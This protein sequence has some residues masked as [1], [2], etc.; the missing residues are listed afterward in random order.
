[1]KCKIVKLS[2]F[3]GNKAS[4][5]T[6]YLSDDNLTLFDIFLNENANSFKS[7]TLDILKRL[8]TIGKYTGAQINFFK[9]WEGKPGDGVCA[10]YDNPGSNLRL[11]CIRYGADIIILGGGGYK[12]K[13]IRALQEDPKLKNENHFLRELSQKITQRIK[14]KEIK[15]SKDGLDF[16]GDLEFNEN[17]NE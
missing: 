2:K 3:S 10:L 17:D 15:Y 4:I 7:E 9:D 13:S 8:N 16:Q 12:P 14:D 6:I 1:M 11:Y 5:Y